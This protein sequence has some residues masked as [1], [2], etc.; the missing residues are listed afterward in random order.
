[1]TEMQSNRRRQA[2]QDLGLS[3]T[4]EQMQM[5]HAMQQ[6][7]QRQMKKQLRRLEIEQSL[8]Y[9]T[10]QSISKWMDKYFLDPL[11]GFFAPGIGD[12]LTSLLVVPFI[13][14]AACKI[15]SLSLTLAIIFNVLRDMA[16]GLIPFWIGDILDVF[17]RAYLQN[18][19]LIV[20]FVEDDREI[21]H[22]VNR[23]AVWTGIMI[24]VLCIIIYYLVKLVTYIGTLIADFFSNLF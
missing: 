3:D 20:G 21:I 16:I 8:S 7:E 10:V 1:M 15:R 4:K 17:N 9:R 11:I 23:K 13:Y 24:L 19:R 2:Q 12:A 14:V 6:E 5:E 18:C 22:E